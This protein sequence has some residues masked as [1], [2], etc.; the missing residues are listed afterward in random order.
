MSFLQHCYNHYHQRSPL[1]QISVRQVER[2]FCFLTLIKSVVYLVLEAYYVKLQMNTSSVNMSHESRA[3]LDIQIQ[4]LE[5][6]MCQIGL[7]YRELGTSTVFGYALLSAILVIFY[8][9]DEITLG[10][11][12]KRYKQDSFVL[13]N[14]SPELS[15]AHL[16][17]LIEHCTKQ[18]LNANFIYCHRATYDRQS[19][20]RSDLSQFSSP[21]MEQK[22]IFDYY[23]SDHGRIRLHDRTD[24]WLR[25]QRRFALA[26]YILINVV[27][28]V[29]TI[30]ANLLTQYIAFTR[31]QTRHGDTFR[32]NFMEKLSF[33]EQPIVVIITLNSF[34]TPM[35]VL[36]LNLRD[37]AIFLSKLRAK[38]AKLELSLT[39]MKSITHKLFHSPELRTDRHEAEL[40]KWRMRSTL[41]A[42]D[43]YIRLRAFMMDLRPTIKLFNMIMNQLFFYVFSVVAPTLAFYSDLDSIIVKILSVI[44]VQF[45]IAINLAFIV[46]AAFNATCVRTTMIAW[47]LLARS[48][49]ESVV[50]TQADQIIPSTVRQENL[51]CLLDTHTMTLWRRLVENQEALLK[52]FPCQILAAIRLDYSNILRLNFWYISIVLI[53]FTDRQIHIISVSSL[54]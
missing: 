52:Q 6:V 37:R 12:S 15:G 31:L 10:Q 51:H 19:R 38:F 22:L 39:Q 21:F 54:T 13:A 23:L 20:N 29:G 8:F 35:A 11:A 42:L 16:R 46:C 25:E 43:I 9:I 34:A 30:F 24:R 45:I 36:V 26:I 44:A 49:L 7:G 40:E 1:R 5:R 14:M 17:K 18:A 4:H 33:I 50:D 27:F 28:F 2:A 48:I 47:R 3:A 53:F 41:E 32:F